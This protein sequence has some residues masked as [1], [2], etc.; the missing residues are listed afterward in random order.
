MNNPVRWVDPTGLFAI[1]GFGLPGGSGLQMVPNLPSLDA[2][3]QAAG[4]GSS[5]TVFD[6]HDTDGK[7]TKAPFAR[8]PAPPFMSRSEWTIHPTP[9][10]PWVLNPNPREIIVHHTVSSMP[11]GASREV[12]IQ[13]MRNMED[14]HRR[15]GPGYPNMRAMGYNYLIAPDGTIIQGRPSGVAGQHSSS[16]NVGSIGIGVIGDFSYNP[17]T[18]EQMAS[19]IWLVDHLKSENPTILNVYGH[20]HFYNQICPG[21]YLT[22]FIINRWNQTNNTRKRTQ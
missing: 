20:N 17:P 22:E 4:G 6:M 9:R 12:M 16:R 8:T 21:P 13:R 3:R 7:G 19:L 2:I 15:Q 11:A 18:A 10:T 1:P 14:W 5:N